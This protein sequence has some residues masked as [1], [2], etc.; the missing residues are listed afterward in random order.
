MIF[1]QNN[2]IVWDVEII[3]YLTFIET[4]F[5][6]SNEATHWLYVHVF[7]SIYDLNFRR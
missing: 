7:W 2:Q 4:S 6:L 5:D 1:V 3:F